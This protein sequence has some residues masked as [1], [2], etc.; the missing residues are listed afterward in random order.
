M[1]RMSEMVL[2]GHPDKFCDQVA[3]ALI[4]EAVSADPLAYGQVEVAVWSDQVWLSGA[5]CTRTPIARTTREVV[6]KTGERIG[7]R[8]G[9]WID[10]CRYKIHDT[11]CRIVEDP[12]K[13]THSVN[14]QAIVV[15]WAGDD[16]Q[17]A[18]L[19]PEHF[20]AHC[21]REALEEACQAGELTG[22]GPDGK[23]LVVMDEDDSK[24]RV[25]SILV[26]LQQRPQ[27]STLT[28]SSAV[29]TTLR[30][31]YRRMQQRDSRWCAKWTDIAL[32]INPNGP[33]LQG[34]SDGDNGQTGR[35]LAMDY[36]GPRVGQ[37]GGALYGK[38]LSHIDRVASLHARQ[39]AVHA[40]ATG[41]EECLVRLA[42]A[43]NRPVPI[44]VDWE[45]HGSGQK[46]PSEFFHF[47]QM[48]GRFSPGLVGGSL[49]Q[50]G[51]FWSTELPWNQPL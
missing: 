11:V 14:D 47:E 2:S 51:H 37:G 16:A 38:H 23:L 48:E 27:T 35:K 24:W 31:A 40:V 41:A 4:A 21:L 30:Q 46:V 7:Y 12:I 25:R 8:S 34:G 15:G 42:Y 19:P 50:K 6:V 36:Y 32:D 22:E 10:V 39:A 26:T 49:V 9:N 43:P 20:L 33:F 29:D 1:I 45:L 13:W 28:L 3:D 44:E 5:L 17:T 18:W